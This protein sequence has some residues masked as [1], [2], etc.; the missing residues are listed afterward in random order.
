MNEVRPL[1]QLSS[2]LWKA[3]W[4]LKGPVDAAD[5]KT[6]IF[7]LLFFKRLSDVH[8]EEHEAALQEFDGDGEAALF[9]ENY[10]FQIPEGCHWADV[11]QVAV[12]VGQ[13]LQIALRGI[14]QANPHTLYGIFGDAQW[15]N[16]D[17][18]P[19]KLTATTALPDALA[20]WLQSSTAV[21]SSLQTLL[22]SEK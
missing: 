15:T 2:S 10:R 8:D 9:P 14:E 11:R 4:H 13:A 12:N 20:G 16:K 1:S 17:R 21:R 18:L 3:A 7:P 22:F 19:D 5:F 6:Y